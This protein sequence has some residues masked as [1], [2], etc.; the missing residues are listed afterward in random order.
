MS[1]LKGLLAYGSLLVIVFLMT[2]ILL[3]LLTYTSSWLFAA[4]LVVFLYT[5]VDMIK[6]LRRKYQT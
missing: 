1:F 2:A 5:A 6:K 4:T 3:F